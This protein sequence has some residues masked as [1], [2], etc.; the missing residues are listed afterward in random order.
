MTEGYSHN[1]WYDQSL[2]A[3]SAPA[4]GSAAR[5]RNTG[6]KVTMIVICVLLLIVASVYAFSDRTDA[7]R[8]DIGGGLTLP[9]LPF[10]NGGNGAN[11]AGDDF[12]AFFSEYYSGASDGQLPPSA[13]ERTRGDPDF[14]V[15]LVSAEGQPALSLQELYRKNIGSVVGVRTYYEDLHGYGWGTGIIL[16]EDG[17]IVTNQHLVAEAV[18]AVVVLADGSE[19]DALLIGEDTQTDIAVLKIKARGL[20]PAEFGDSNALSVGDQVAAIGNPLGV[21]LTGTMTDGIVSAINRDIRRDGRSMTLIQ[22]NAAINEGNSGGPLLNEYGQVIGII[23]M[24]MSNRYSAVTI[25]GIGFAIPSATIKAVCDQLIANGAITGRPGLG[26]TLTAVEAAVAEYYGLPEG[27]Y[28]YSISE[29]SDAAAKG[30]EVGDIV[31]RVN[32]RAVRSTEEVLEIRN[33]LSVGDPMTLTL[34]R[35][36]ETFDVTIELRELNALY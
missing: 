36:G 23:N 28:V 20:T 25:E 16:S 10:G 12:R 33:A 13:M 30:V 3:V 5:R 24:K 32:G 15:R 34:W 26:I 8:I 19:Y 18:R 9:A 1:S 21:S 6:M 22:T 17:Y 35:D 14:A 29:N 2:P 11:S 27:L 7:V 31:T 4:A